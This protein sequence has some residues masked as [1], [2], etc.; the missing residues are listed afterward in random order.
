MRC[1]RRFLLTPPLHERGARVLH[2]RGDGGLQPEEEL[3]G[4]EE[5]AT[6]GQLNLFDQDP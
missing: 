6:G 4:I 5:L 2:I 1:H 3:R